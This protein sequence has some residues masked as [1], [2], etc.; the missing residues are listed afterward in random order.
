MSADLSISPHLPPTS[1]NKYIYE[2]LPNVGDIRLLTLY[3]Y[4]LHQ[5]IRCNLFIESLA[6][7]PTYEALSYVWG[8]ATTSHVILCNGA[9]L[10]I[11][12][13][14]HTALL[15]L[16]YPDCNRTIWADGICINQENIPERT[17]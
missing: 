8:S 4:Q 5:S 7:K 9:E 14:L 10:R 2:P 17:T 1:L 12:Q 11:T 3:P 15:Q 13:N 16:C 6:E